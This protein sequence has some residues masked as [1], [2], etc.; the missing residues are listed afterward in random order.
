[1]RYPVT[2][3]LSV[4]PVHARFTC[5]AV[6]V[7]VRVEGALGGCESATAS[8]RFQG[9]GPTPAQLVPLRRVTLVPPPASFTFTAA[10]LLASA[11]PEL[12]PSRSLFPGS[13]TEI[14]QY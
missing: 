10:Q 11:L 1:M 5:V 13:A 2:P 8:S 4:A 3:T 9:S 7:A 14:R 6:V 12:L